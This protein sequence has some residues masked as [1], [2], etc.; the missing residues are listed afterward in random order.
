MLRMSDHGVEV[1]RLPLVYTQF[2][3][4]EKAPTRTFAAPITE[5]IDPEDPVDPEVEVVPEVVIDVQQ[6]EIVVQTDT[7]AAVEMPQMAVSDTVDADAQMDMGS[8]GLAAAIG[9]GGGNAGSFG[10]GDFFAAMGTGG[11]GSGSSFFGVPSGS[12]NDR[13]FFIIDMS[14]SLKGPQMFLIKD[15]LMGTIEEMQPHEQF[16]I[17]FFSGPVWLMGDDYKSLQDTW[18][19]VTNWYNYLPPVSGLP[20]G[21]WRQKTPTVVNELQSYVQALDKSGG[22]DWRH[23]FEVAYRMYPQPDVIFFLTDGKVDN[24][25]LTLAQVKENRDIPVMTIA[26]GLN[27]KDGVAALEEMSTLTRGEHIAITMDRIEELYQAEQKELVR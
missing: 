27:D 18:T 24:S 5:K 12:G 21:R 17:A 4:V 22:T 11:K 25:E 3:E 26:F 8:T 10:A 23:P 2:I 16:E 9:A 1:M 6:V 14:G 13:M 20:M 19:K 7:D 15:R